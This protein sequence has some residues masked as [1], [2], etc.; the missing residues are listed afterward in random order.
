M[1]ELP[2][3]NRRREPK[4]ADGNNSGQ[5]ALSPQ[6]FI[7]PPPLL[8]HH[9]M[10]TSLLD[11]SEVILQPMKDG[12]GKRTF[13]LGP[14][15]TM[16]SH[17]WIKMPK[18]KPIKSPTTRHFCSSYT[19]QANSVGTKSR[20][21]WDPIVGGLIPW[22]AATIPFLILTF[23][24]SELT[25]PP[26][27]EPSQLNEPAI[28]GPSQFSEPQVPSHEDALT[29]RHPDDSSRL[30]EHCQS[31]IPMFSSSQH[32]LFSFT[33]FLQG[34]IGNIF[35]RDIQEAVPKQVVK[36]QCSVNPTWQPHSFPYSLD[37]SIPLFQSYI[38]GKSFNTVHFPVWR[39]IHSI[40][41]S[42]PLPVFNTDQL[43]A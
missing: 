12:K 3:G 27:V 28:P 38:M 33:V 20:P 30:K 11:H 19:L 8:G 24:S 10:V 5:L 22:Q 35:S 32:W 4:Q 6:V 42:I 43:P 7:C 15:V 21:K 40:R 26:F 2:S 34:N 29:S 17:H 37:S 14:I 36:C 9:L 23:D 41:Q 18:T 39:G 1:K 31:Q 16:S 13:E 25:L